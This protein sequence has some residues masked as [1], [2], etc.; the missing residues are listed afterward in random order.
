MGK[1]YGHGS[2][3]KDD[4]DVYGFDSF[5]QVQAINEHWGG[6]IADEMR[7]LRHAYIRDS[8]NGDQIDYIKAHEA[9]EGCV[10][11]LDL[12]FLWARQQLEEYETFIEVLVDTEV[13][14]PTVNISSRGLQSHG[15][16]G[17]DDNDEDGDGDD[18]NNDGG[19]CQCSCILSKL[20]GGGDEKGDGNGDS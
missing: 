20:K 12:V 4:C 11:K 15:D 18:D 19:F 1:K 16:D 5:M 3:P 14:L 6:L 10:Q 7:M 17:D 2:R 9:A 13:P 8:K